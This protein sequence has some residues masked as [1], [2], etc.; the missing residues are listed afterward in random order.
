MAEQFTLRPYDEP[1][2]RHGAAGDWWSLGRV[3]SSIQ[4][5]D[6]SIRTFTVEVGLSITPHGDFLHC[7]EDFWRL[8]AEKLPMIAQQLASAARRR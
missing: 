1:L 4:N 3:E 7:E 6:G 8:V 2:L 5:P